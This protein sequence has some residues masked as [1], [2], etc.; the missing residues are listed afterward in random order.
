MEDWAYPSIKKGI[1]GSEE[2]IIYLSQEL[3]RLGYQVTV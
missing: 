2:A 1:G 3:V